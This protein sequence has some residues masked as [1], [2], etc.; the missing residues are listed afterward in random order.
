MF[1]IRFALVEESRHAFG[2]I[3]QPERGMKEI[4]FKVHALRERGLEHAID[5]VFCRNQE[6]VQILRARGCPE[7]KLL[8]TLGNGVSGITYSLKT[9]KDLISGDGDQKGGK[10][11]KS[12][13][14]RWS[15][16]VYKRSYL[17]IGCRSGV[18]SVSGL[19]REAFPQ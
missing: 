8:G 11:V 10:T 2:A 9:N 14:E 16:A 1:E 5:G 4:A 19:T 12:R 7:E 18:P 15:A 13:N 6:V 17:R 3:F